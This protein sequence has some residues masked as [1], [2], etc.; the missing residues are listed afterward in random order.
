MILRAA[1]ACV[2]GLIAYQIRDMIRYY[3]DVGMK[4]YR[5]LKD[6]APVSCPNITDNADL[7]R[8]VSRH[9]SPYKHSSGKPQMILLLGGSGVGKTFAARE[10]LKTLPNNSSYVLH[11]LDDYLSLSPAYPELFQDP[12]FIYKTAAQDCYPSIIPIAKLMQAEILRN[13]LNLVYEETGKDPVRLVERVI[14]PFLAAGYQIHALLVNAHP[15]VAVVRSSI[16]F[17]E[18]GRFASEEYVRSSFPPSNISELIVNL[19]MKLTTCSND[20]MRGLL[21]PVAAALQRDCLVCDN[22]IPT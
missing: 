9:L 3:D 5:G 13:R 2:L 15:S 14:K 1:V 10:L 18:T 21:T 16:R 6:V 7:E 17:L 19:G 11:G 12:K 22:S 4:T 20:C 8:I